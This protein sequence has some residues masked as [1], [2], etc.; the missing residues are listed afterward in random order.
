[1]PAIQRGLTVVFLRALTALL[2]LT[3]IPAAA[4]SPARLKTVV[5]GV[6]ARRG[7]DPALAP[8]LS[9]V[10]QSVY[11]A[12]S[13]RQVFGRD[14][15]QRVL[16]FEAERA[17]VGCDAGA[18]LSEIATALDADRLVTGSI[19][20]IG[21]TYLLVLNEIDARTV[22]PLARAQRQV[23]LDEDQVVK[24]ITEMSRELLARAL[25]APITATTEVAGA[26]VTES[27]ERGFLLINVLPEGT[28]VL[29][30]GQP[31]G[32]SPL[33]IGDLTAGSH[34]IE[35]VA[36][37][38]AP[39]SVEAEVFS[40][41]ETVISG[42]L[43]VATA[44][45]AAKAPRSH[46]LGWSALLCGA[47]SCT[48]GLCLGGALA[49]AGL[50]DSTSDP[51]SDDSTLTAVTL[52]PILCGLGA[53]GYGAYDVWLSDG[54]AE[55]SAPPTH[56]LVVTPPLGKGAPRELRLNAVTSDVM[57]H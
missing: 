49:D 31:R 42:K 46:W 22:E 24:A 26:T 18:C 28:K 8:A 34:Q 1:M 41:G 16:Q 56:Q 14:D 10:V 57:A 20:K 36:T 15:L 35:L 53:C 51:V 3:A 40:A 54:D 2:V 11:A 12:D 33:R 43:G 50:D 5:I 4:E 47:T 23:A 9:D 13:R 27:P 25:G 45:E 30:G 38:Y 39:V 29:L 52:L 6:S 19:D 7:I 17:A 55:E 21:S 32:E 48:G 37:G 44:P